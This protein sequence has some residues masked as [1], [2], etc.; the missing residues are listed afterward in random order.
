[1]FFVVG[2]NPRPNMEPFFEQVKFVYPWKSAIFF[3]N[4]VTQ[5]PLRCSALDKK[6]KL[7]EKEPSPKFAAAP[8][9][10]T[11]FRVRSCDIIGSAEALPILCV[12]YIR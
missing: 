4:C 5:S 8:A 6:K 12:R 2:E 10:R 9:R 11:L 7:S 1:M 3:S